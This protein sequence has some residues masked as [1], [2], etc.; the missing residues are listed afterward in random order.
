VITNIPLVPAG[1]VVE[2]AANPFHQPSLE[3]ISARVTV[4]SCDVNFVKQQQ[5]TWTNGFFIDPTISTVFI[6][7]IFIHCIS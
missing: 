1:A 6:G 5:Q 2:I 7:T 3:T 4:R